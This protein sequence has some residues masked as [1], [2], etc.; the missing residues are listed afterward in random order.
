MAQIA[1]SLQ[2]NDQKTE[3]AIKA[4]MPA[5]RHDILKVISAKESKDILSSEGKD[6]LAAE[7]A[8]VAAERLGWKGG[9]DDEEGDVKS[10]S[11]DADKGDKKA[12]SSI[13]KKKKKAKTVAAP[14]PIDQ[15]H[16]SQF[17]VQ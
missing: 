13:K 17:I 15:V 11:K 8:V 10:D 7:I 1:V 14:N 3:E 4:Y 12:E 6:K 9:D 16:F 5:L 2:V